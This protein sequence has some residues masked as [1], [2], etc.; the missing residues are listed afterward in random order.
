[1]SRAIRDNLRA[2]HL[3]F[4]GKNKERHHLEGLFQHRRN[5]VQPELPRVP[6]DDEESHLP[7]HERR[8]QAI[9][10]SVAGSAVKR[11]ERNNAKS[12]R[13]PKHNSCEYH[14]FLGTPPPFFLVQSATPV[15]CAWQRILGQTVVPPKGYRR[16]KRRH[17]AATPSDRWRKT[18]LAA[19]A[20]QVLLQ[21]AAQK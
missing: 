8:E 19:I 20:A 6:A 21:A 1:M 11:N 4:G 15:A 12:S 14:V 3:A 5:H 16:S 18:S 7:G 9:V 17:Y 2:G 13:D 10:D